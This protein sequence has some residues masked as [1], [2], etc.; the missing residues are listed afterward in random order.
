MKQVLHNIKRTLVQAAYDLVQYRALQKEIAKEEREKRQKQRKE[1]QRER[2]RKSLRG[3]DTDNAVTIWREVMG[4]MPNDGIHEIHA[5]KP[6]GSDGSNYLSFAYRTDEDLEAAL[7][8]THW[9]RALDLLY[10]DCSHNYSG[11]A[12]APWQDYWPFQPGANAKVGGQPSSRPFMSDCYYYY[13]D[14]EQSRLFLS[15]GMTNDKMD[16]EIRRCIERYEER[17]KSEKAG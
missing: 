3:P 10:D 14:R 7:S 6:Y 15:T 1:T 2:F 16:E 12:P 5:A 17:Q 9:G 11:K 8:G 4:K 13:L